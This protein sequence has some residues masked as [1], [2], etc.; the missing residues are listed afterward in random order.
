[1]NKT[2]SRKSVVQDIPV[3]DDLACQ[4]HWIIEAPAGPVSM[5]S[6]RI[7]GEDRE[8]RNYAEGSSWTSSDLT[9][10]HLSGG[11]RFPTGPRAG[12]AAPD[13]DD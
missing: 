7:C 5:G 3:V 11:S 8:F 6:C 10:E 4:H 2:S 13:E 12:E 1:M 9:L